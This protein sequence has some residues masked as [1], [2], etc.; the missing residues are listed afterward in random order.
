[1]LSKD[2][3]EDVLNASI[4]P[5]NNLDGVSSE[6]NGDDETNVIAHSSNRNER[7]RD[8]LRNFVKK[9]ASLSLQDYKW[10]SE[11]FK[12]NEADALMEKSLARMRGEDM[13]Y[14]RPMDASDEQIGPLVSFSIDK[15]FFYNEYHSKPFIYARYRMYH[16]VL[17]KKKLYSGYLM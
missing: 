14:V 3:P 15:E 5:P 2:V 16:R 1:M 17:P 11:V 10:R 6:D 13:A 7:K 8:R 12:N 9:I 4:L